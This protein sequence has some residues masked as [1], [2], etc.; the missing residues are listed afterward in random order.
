MWV[1]VVMYGRAGLLGLAVFVFT[2]MFAIGMASPIVPLYASSM[3]ASWLELGLMGTVWGATLTLLSFISGRIS[4]SVGRKPLLVASGGL[5][6]V[7]ALLYLLSQTV[8]Q[9]L[10]I[11]VL[12]G[13]AWAL[14]WPTVEALSTE[15]V[16]TRESGR[17]IGIT[18][19][20]YG[21]AF[22]CGPLVGG[23]TAAILGYTDVFVFYFTISLVSVAI[24]IFI[25]REPQRHNEVASRRDGERTS[26]NWHSAFSRPPLLA[27]FL[28]AMYTFGL[29]IVLTLLSVFGKDL[30]VAVLWIGVLFAFFGLGRVVGSFGGGHLSDRYGRASIAILAMIGSALGFALIVAAGGIELLLIAAIVLGF[31]IGAA[32]PVGVALISD[33]VAQSV[34]GYAMGI[35][36]TSCAA[37]YMTASTAGG[38]LAD[39]SPRAPY[40]LATMTSLATVVILT[41]ALPRE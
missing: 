2:L 10:V 29:G 35:F 30:G 28:G 20:A 36:E 13:A 21:V 22:T 25:L 40:L 23:S 1:F 17:A 3:G 33:N 34:R 18:T 26:F 24:A 39:F 19:A 15:I 11:R 31:S 32:F 12:E 7:A 5:S 16:D 27:Y 9:V 6:T 14:F 4:D 8:G 38:L 41:L 37:G